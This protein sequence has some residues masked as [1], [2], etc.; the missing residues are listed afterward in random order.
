[1][2]NLESEFTGWL[3]GKNKASEKTIHHYIHTLSVIGEF[4]NS[5]MKENYYNKNFLQYTSSKLF[6]NIY[7]SILED[8]T[9]TIIEIVKGKRPK[10]SEN[11]NELFNKFMEYEKQN[12]PTEIVFEDFKFGS[13]LRT[14]LTFLYEFNHIDIEEEILNEQNEQ[15][16]IKQETGEI[17]NTNNLYINPELPHPVMYYVDYVTGDNLSYDDE[18]YKKYRFIKGLKYVDNDKYINSEDKEKFHQFLEEFGNIPGYSKCILHLLNSDYRG[19]I[20]LASIPSSKIDKVSIT[21]KVVDY[22]CN[23]DARFINANNL[24][25]KVNN[26]ETAHEKSGTRNWQDQL[27]SLSVNTI[28]KE[29]K[30]YPILV[31]DDVMTSGSSFIAIYKLLIQSL[32][33]DKENIYF[34]SYGRTIKHDNYIM[35]NTTKNIPKQNQSIDSIIFDLDQTIFDN[36]ILF[37]YDMREQNSRGLVTEMLNDKKIKLFDEI[38][39][40]MSIVQTNKNLKIAFVSNRGK[41]AQTMLDYFKDELYIT[42]DNSDTNF[43]LSFKDCIVEDEEQKLFRMKPDSYLIDEAIKKM[44]LNTETNRVIGIGN[45][46]NDISAYNNANIES[47]LVNWGNDQIIDNDLGANYVFDTVNEFK[48]FIANNLPK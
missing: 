22:V 25:Q 24:I 27:Q 21:N 28:P 43:L 10:Y 12:H 37:N 11:Q 41:T 31:I 40:L 9:E 14:Y 18:T 2:K 46:L 4:L 48:S 35:L 47:V 7:Q 3:I 45:A 1:M 19:K 32:G 16:L 5:E 23:K 30:N 13:V 34:Y 6:K 29:Y 42:N 39:E 8:D 15:Q 17:L 20:L 44:G 38:K 36:S 26:T 33:I